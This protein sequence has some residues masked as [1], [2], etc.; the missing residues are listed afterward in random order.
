MLMKLSLVQL[1]L[2]FALALSLGLASRYNS[3]KIGNRIRTFREM[4][5]NQFSGIKL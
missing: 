4:K 3:E 1:V 5:R 2:L